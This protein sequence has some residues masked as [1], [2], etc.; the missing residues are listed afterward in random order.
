MTLFFNMSVAHKSTMNTNKFVIT[1]SNKVILSYI[2]TFIRLLLFKV[3]PDQSVFGN[4]TKSFH[5]ELQNQV[6]ENKS[7]ILNEFFFCQSIAFLDITDVKSD[8]IILWILTI[9]KKK[10][11]K[12]R[13]NLLHPFHNDLCF[14]K[15]IM[16]K[17]FIF[18]IFNVCNNDKLQILKILIVFTEFWLVKNHKK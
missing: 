17:K 5:L 7:Y 13:S 8:F 6:K 14:R 1:P 10:K 18:Y 12:E 9:A 2:T 3:K 16:S 4:Q 15:K 11:K